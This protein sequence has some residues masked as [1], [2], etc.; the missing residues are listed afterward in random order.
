M[1]ES[2]RSL[3]VAGVQVFD[4]PRMTGENGS[5]IV[6]EV[7]SSLPFVVKRIFTLLEVPQAEARGIH[8][9]R[10][11]EQFLICQRGAVTAVV[12][13]GTNREELR[14]DSP[15][16]GLYMPPMTWGT[17]YNYSP[18]AILLVLASDTYDRADYI[19]DYDEYLAALDERGVE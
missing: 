6:G 5:L 8:A 7:G 16:T 19:E 3:T 11:C 17:Q 18:D 10:K 14:L 2:P 12:D 4:L 9:H 15:S 1:A 13:D